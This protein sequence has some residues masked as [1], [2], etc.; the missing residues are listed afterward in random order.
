MWPRRPPSDQNTL[1][2]AT[3]II[4]GRTGTVIGHYDL[5]QDLAP[6]QKPVIVAQFLPDVRFWT[7]LK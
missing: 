2:Y 6:D 7:H 5:F 4:S 1:R 3:I